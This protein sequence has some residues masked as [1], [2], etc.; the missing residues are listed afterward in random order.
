MDRCS[1]VTHSGLIYNFGEINKSV[2][3]EYQVWKRGRANQGCVEKY[4]VKKGKWEAKL[5]S[6]KQKGY[7][8]EYQV[9]R[10]EGA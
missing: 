5:S 8:K 10:G 2:G 1:S 4:N 6:L 9:G 7:W 3:E